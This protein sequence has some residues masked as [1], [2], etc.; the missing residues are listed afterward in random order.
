MGGPFVKFRS[1][2]FG[3]ID[4]FSCTSSPNASLTRPSPVAPLV[5]LAAEQASLVGASVVSSHRIFVVI[6]VR[7]GRFKQRHHSRMRD[8]HGCENFTPAGGQKVVAEVNL[9]GGA[10]K[11]G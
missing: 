6:V 8:S 4:A 9:D 3:I 2:R 7:T 1:Y 11:V 5:D 10:R